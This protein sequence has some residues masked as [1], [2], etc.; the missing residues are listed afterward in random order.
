MRL[1]V[2][3]GAGRWRGRCRHGHF[4]Y[5]MSIFE[6]QMKEATIIAQLRAYATALYKI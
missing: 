2:L 3:G 5:N 1:G 4:G 6:C